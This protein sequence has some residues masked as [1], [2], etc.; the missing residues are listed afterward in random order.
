MNSLV[1]KKKLSFIFCNIGK[2]FY[3]LKFINPQKM[4]PIQCEKKFSIRNENTS[5]KFILF[6]TFYHLLHKKDYQAFEIENEKNI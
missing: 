5:R 6:Y 4:F 1:N 2:V 3:L